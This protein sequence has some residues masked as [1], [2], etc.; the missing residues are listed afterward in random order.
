MIDFLGQLI[1]HTVLVHRTDFF[2]SQIF[3]QHIR[4]GIIMPFGHQLGIDFLR[5][6]DSVIMEINHHVSLDNDGIRGQ[7]F[8]GS[9]ISADLPGL[10]R[11]DICLE[12]NAAYLQIR[13]IIYCR[14]GSNNVEK[15][16]RRKQDCNSHCDPKP[17]FDVPVDFHM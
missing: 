4:L 15:K 10:G 9:Q 2:G 17:F 1:A 5:V 8:N 7:P 16:N 12:I 14:L 6:C 3:R 13:S 11:I